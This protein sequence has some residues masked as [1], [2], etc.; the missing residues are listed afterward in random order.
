M[1]SV[2]ERLIGRLNAIAKSLR[3]SER[4]LALLALGSSG[5][6]RH[7]LDAYSDLDFFVIAQPG[8]KQWF[9]HNR[10][11][12]AAPVAFTFAN[13]VDG[14]KTLYADELFAE[15]AVFEPDELTG[16]PYP[17]G[18]IVWHAP[19]FDTS[20]ATPPTR[21]RQPAR[22]SWMLGEALTNL[23]I[24]LGRW[25]RGE[26]M[27]G[28]AFIQQYAVA[29]VLQL[30]AH[31][32]TPASATD[33]DPFDATRRLEQRFPRLAARLPAMLP[34]YA[35]TPAAAAAILSFLSEHFAVDPAMRRAIERR[36]TE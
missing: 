15:W 21:T 3:E 28:Y 16:I 12:L 5:L 26:K 1:R 27:S 7:R 18:H 11:W 35:E 29:Q 25:H 30:A 33:A 9:L 20:L 19:G 10:D 23:Y 4:A 36:L 31:A 2:P 24:G 32:E 17:P 13:T 6:E 14:Y 34:G 22:P 8:Q